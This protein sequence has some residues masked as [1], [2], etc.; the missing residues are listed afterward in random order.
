MPAEV[1]TDRAPVYRRVLNELAPA[2]RHITEQYQ[3][4][5][6]ETAHSRLK[7][8][9]RPMRPMLG[10]KRW[11]SARAIAAGHAFVQNLRRGHYELT[12]DLPAPKRVRAAFDELA[13]C[14]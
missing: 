3:N 2:A 7:A 14:L 5:V 8:R 1:T 11:A 12:T 9:L 13:V 4:N 10:P 6:I